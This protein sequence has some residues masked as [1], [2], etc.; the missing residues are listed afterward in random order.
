M[1]DI[2]IEDLRNAVNALGRDK[3]VEQYSPEQLVALENL[4]APDEQARQKAAELLGKDRPQDSIRPVTEMESEVGKIVGGSLA[5]LLTTGKGAQVGETVGRAVGAGVTKSPVGTEIGGKVG[6]FLGFGIESALL[7][8]AGGSTGR[9]AE[10][11]YSNAVNDTEFDTSL[12]AALSAG[13]DEAMW[14][15]AGNA[16]FKT[17]G[18]L[19]NMMKFRPKDGTKEL[20]EMLN[21]QGTTLSLDQAVDNKVIN[22]MGELLRGSTLSG[23]GF[24]KLAS[25]QS[26]V[27][28]KFYDDL[29]SDFVDVTRSGLERGGVARMLKLAIKD[30]KRLHQEAANV[31]FSKLDD[32]VILRAG[33]PKTV[34]SSPRM[35]TGGF[36]KEEVSVFKPPVDVS[37]IRGDAKDIL[38]ELKEIGIIDPSGQ[39]AKLLTDL[40]KGKSNLTFSQTHELIAQLKRLQRD[41]DFKGPAAVR[42]GDFI[43]GLQKQFDSAASELP[44]DLSKIYKRARTFSKLGASRFNQDFI[45]KILSEDSPSVIAK[46]ISKST[47]E[48]I[49][50]LRKA[51]SLAEKRG[52]KD[53]AGLWKKTQGAVL[54]EILPQKIDDIGKTAISADTRE[55]NRMLRAVLSPEE[56]NRVKRG[57]KLVEQLAE[58][59]K[60]RNTVGYQQSLLLLGTGAAG[61]G[62]TDSGYGAIL[63][64][65]AAPR[66]MAWAMTNKKVVNSLVALNKYDP[67]KPSYKL[68]VGKLLRLLGEGQAELEETE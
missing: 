21:K 59:E 54:N 68:A 26:D 41:K 36:T 53:S 48:D 30:G 38:N 55:L 51:L 1:T 67:S 62:T 50:R 44:D 7:A 3:L 65:L 47:P 16:L 10:A 14:D 40:S 20:Q 58:K 39:G 13:G 12:K 8:G 63:S 57:T 52:A 56:Y 46:M 64:L 23:G 43:G 22:F 60:K 5:P 28:I 9:Q 33:K 18:K 32:G 2:N 17:G 61:Y 25:D 35:G 49:I 4:L 66:M 15:V 6:R 34:K 11:L 31:L 37:P 45:V 42:I 19:W 27:V 29:V 24:E